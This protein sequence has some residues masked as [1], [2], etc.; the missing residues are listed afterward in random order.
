[1]PL[2]RILIAVLFLGA[3]VS[4]KGDLNKGKQV[5]A[6]LDNAEQLV[7]DAHIHT[8]FD[9]TV[10]TYSKVLDSRKGLIDEMRQ[11]NVVGAVSLMSRS[12]GGWSDLSD[13]N[14]IHCVGIGKKIDAVEV[15]AGLK[16]GRYQCIKI[17]L[18]Y[19]YRYAFDREY[20]P[21]YRL[22]EKYDI[23]VVFHTG[24]TYSMD[25]KLKFADPLTI[26]EVAVDFRKV[27]FVIAHVGNPWI[28]SAAE[29]VYKNSNVYADV[30]ALLIGNLEEYSPEQ[31]EEYIVKPIRWAFGYIEN[32]EKLM[33]GTD[34][35]LVHMGPYLAA[36]K[37]AI[38]KEHWNDV[39]Y[40]NALR[41]FKFPNLKP[42]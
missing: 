39:F 22:A 17:Y 4:H 23:P 42:L 34:W 25:G 7:I 41:V 8:D 19:V 2:R 24:D 27:R 1:M 3:C 9:D 36:V 14:I 38:P 29:V 5:N 12:G 40:N 33:Y 11:N 15:E 35:P 37:R 32:S 26:D 20:H 18:G 13:Q 16:S 10:K 6:A 21:L 28:Q 30:S 31:I